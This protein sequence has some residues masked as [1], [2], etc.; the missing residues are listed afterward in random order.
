MIDV[1]EV[2]GTLV[3]EL[4]GETLDAH[5]CKAVRRELDTQLEGRK[6]VVL[7]LLRLTFVDSSGLGVLLSCLRQVNAAGG[8][9]KICGLHAQVRSVFQL[10]RMH[11]VFEIHNT[12]D[13]AV[14]AF[15]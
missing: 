14:R 5:T 4:A 2:N 6:Q 8:S 10:T 1:E 11:S 7:D 15:Q 3:V 13:E 9:M 12:R